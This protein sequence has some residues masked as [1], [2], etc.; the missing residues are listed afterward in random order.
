MGRGDGLSCEAGEADPWGEARSPV[1]T[2]FLSG[3]WAWGPRASYFP[4]G[5]RG[6]SGAGTVVVIPSTMA[7]AD[8]SQVLS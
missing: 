1:R 6:S 7:A 3:L 5:E 8:A 2:V 4:Y